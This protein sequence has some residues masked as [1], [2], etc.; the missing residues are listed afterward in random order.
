[1]VWEIKKNYQPRRQNSQGEFNQSGGILV[2]Q[3]DE[4]VSKEAHTI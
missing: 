1:M 4:L 2:N 3:V